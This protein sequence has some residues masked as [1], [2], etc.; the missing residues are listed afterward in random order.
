[1]FS[2]KPVLLGHLAITRS[3]KLAQRFLQLSAD[4]I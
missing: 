2:S 4:S 1:M 3:V